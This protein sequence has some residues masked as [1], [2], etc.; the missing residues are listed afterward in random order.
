[1][2][3]VVFPRVPDWPPLV[4]ASNDPTEAE[5]LAAEFGAPSLTKHLLPLGALT[6]A[7]TTNSVRIGVC[8]FVVL[9]PR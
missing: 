1:M 8:G 9:T 6:L 7:H 4:I 3:V 2:M 5:Y